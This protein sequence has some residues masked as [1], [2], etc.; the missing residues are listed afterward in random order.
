[1]EEF[2]KNNDLLN[3][4]KDYDAFYFANKYGEESTH[5]E[6]FKNLRELLKQDELSQRALNWISQCYDC[7]YK[8]EFEGMNNDNPFYYLQCKINEMEVTNE[9]N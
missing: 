4:W 6:Q 9:N 5:I 1:M 7:Y 2:I 3:I 8:N